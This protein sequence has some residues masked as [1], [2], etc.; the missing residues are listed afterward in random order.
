MDVDL[1][2]VSLFHAENDLCRHEPF[3]RIHEPEVGIHAERDGAF[4]EMSSDR[5]VVH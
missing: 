2:L 4:E 3:I 5:F 1:L